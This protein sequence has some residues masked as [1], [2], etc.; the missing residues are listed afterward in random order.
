LLIP[1]ALYQQNNRAGQHHYQRGHGHRRSAHYKSVKE[2]SAR[3]LVLICGDPRPQSHVK[4][5]GCDNRLKA[6]DQLTQTR[7]LAVKIP[8]GRARSDMTSR[9]ITQALVQL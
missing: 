1:L 9:W 6:V 3:A 8:A 4:I 2:R 7:A 5:S